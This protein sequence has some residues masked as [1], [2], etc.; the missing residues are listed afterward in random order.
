MP[1]A[2]A[3][4]DYFAVFTPKEFERISRG[5][6]PGKMEDKWFIFLEDNTLNFHRSWTGHCI[7]KV[8]FDYDGRQYAVRSAMV[9]RNPKEY[10]QTDSDYDAQL[11]NFLIRNL[12]LGDNTPFPIPSDLPNN[13]SKELYQ[14]HVSGTVPEE[15]KVD[16]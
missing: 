1:E 12:L 4:L 9:N 5:L 10:R 3:E 14:H 7:Y 6:I 16:S 8:E 13:I 2:V 15:R 11:L